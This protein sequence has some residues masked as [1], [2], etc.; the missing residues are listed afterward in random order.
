MEIFIVKFKLN[1]MMKPLFVQQL[2]VF[3]KLISLRFAFPKLQ[4]LE[5]ILVN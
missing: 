2:L 5:I 1:K 4:S 3:V